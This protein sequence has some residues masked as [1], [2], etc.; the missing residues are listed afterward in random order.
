VDGNIVNSKGVLVGVVA[1][2]AVFG[3]KGQKL[4]GLK[5]SS[6]YKLN[7]DLVALHSDFDGL[8][9][10]ISSGRSFE[11]TRTSMLRGVLG[12]LVM[13]PAR[14]SVSTIW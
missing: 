10:Q 9:V 14:S 3:L 12:C 4:Y 7:G 11:S 13:R 5:G 6:I 1:G 8:G 2:D